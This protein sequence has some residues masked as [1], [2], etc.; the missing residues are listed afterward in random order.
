M[1][2]NMKS[3]LAAALSAAFL[4]S[5]IPTLPVGA[6]EGMYP[7]DKI[8]ALPLAEKGL[9]ISPNEIY[10]PNGGGLSEA[11]VRLSI[12]CTGEFVSPDGLILTNH[13]CGFD[14]LVSAS[15][16]KDNY[17]EI[18]YKAND[19]ASELPAQSYSINITLKSEDVTA[20]V[21]NGIN[22]TDAAAVKNRVE[23]LKNAAQ[24]KAGDGVSVQ[25]I[26]INDGL[27]YYRFDYATIQD[28]RVVYAPPYSIGQ[29]GG[30]PDNFEWTR[31]GGDF[32]FLRAYVGKDGK[33]AP[34]SKDNVPYKPKRFLN[35][36][37][38]GVKENDFT[39]IIGYP[40][41]TTRYRESFSVAYNQDLQ[42]PFTVDFRAR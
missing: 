21:L 13:H 17:G 9:K 3:F 22:R 4:L 14:A 16:T 32:T 6:E 12:G 37:T 18:G 19:R 31:H 41:G 33:P 29:F 2:L 11:V 30:D 5:L 10:N 39:M 15:T 38:D 35:V 36:S 40:G 8:A 20:Q 42:L 1:R 25:I 27:F 26:P 24:S 7:L 23:Q 34:Y 28:I